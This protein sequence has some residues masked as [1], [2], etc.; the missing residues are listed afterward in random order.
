MFVSPLQGRVTKKK[1][2]TASGR[3]GGDKEGVLMY[4]Y[5][6]RL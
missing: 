2:W 3:E 6:E 5:R 1:G 4:A